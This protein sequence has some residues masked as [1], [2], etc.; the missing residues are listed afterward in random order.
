MRLLAAS[1]GGPQIIT[2]MEVMAGPELVVPEL[3]PGP[4]FQGSG[5]A[6]LY[7]CCLL[8]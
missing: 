3:I 5:A 6:W 7:C 8:S 2:A 1:L 4:T